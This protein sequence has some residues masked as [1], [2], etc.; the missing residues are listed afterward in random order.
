MALMF[1]DSGTPRSALR[2]H[3]AKLC[4]VVQSIGEGLEVARSGP[5][6]GT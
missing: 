3:F 4:G 6:V 2:W 1:L 5:T